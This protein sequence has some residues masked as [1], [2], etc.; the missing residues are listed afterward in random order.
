[1]WAVCEVWAVLYVRCGVGCAVC[2]VWDVLY[3]RCGVAV[4]EKYWIDLSKKK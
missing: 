2:E 3:V 1:M 4:C